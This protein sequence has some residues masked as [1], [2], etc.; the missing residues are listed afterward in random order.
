MQ[1]FENSL[2]LKRFSFQ[3]FSNY[4]SLLYIAF[5]KPASS[6]RPGYFDSKPNCMVELESQ[7]M[8]LVI[9]K[10]TIQQLL[11][12]GVPFIMSRVK[13]YFS[14]RKGGRVDD[15][16]LVT[17][18]ET[19]PAEQALP[20]AS[21]G[22]N[23]YVAESKLPPYLSTIEDYA[24]M[25][26]QFGFFSLFGLAFPCAAVVNLINNVI[27]VRTDAFKVIQVAQRTNADDAADIGAWY[28]ILQ[29][30]GWFSVLTNAGLVIFTGNSIEYLF[31]TD[32]M[33]Y[34]V[35]AFF[36]LEHI[37]F[38]LKGAAAGLI[39][40]IPGRTHR[41]LARQDY[42]AARA[43]D[44]GW[45]NAFRGTSLLEVS[46]KHRDTARKQCN[47]FVRA[48]VD[49]RSEADARARKEE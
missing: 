37:L 35:V 27:E 44:E 43:F 17:S 14:A 40:D 28:Y 23:R 41:M 8:S 24:E 34:K 32:S 25:A 33:V 30:L 3:F 6:C 22:N 46:D 20:F 29:F 1:Q 11:E 16:E 2:V 38:A 19:A 5:A 31:N 21:G 4:S 15:G 49:G 18:S 12:V 45:Q 26:I 7:M 48:S 13:Q 39:R 42:D 47:V 9:T 10:A 36:V